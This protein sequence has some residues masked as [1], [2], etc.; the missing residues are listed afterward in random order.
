MIVVSDTSAIANLALVSHLWLLNQLYGQVVIPEVVANELAAAE[1]Q[2]IQETLE[3]DWII[4]QS[5]TDLPLATQLQQERGLDAGEAHAIALAV[6][7]EA[8]DLL[9]D[10][11]LGRREAMKLGLSIIGILGVLLAAKGQNHIPAVKPIV[12]DL[13]STAGFRVGAAL[14]QQV[15]ALA[16]ESV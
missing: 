4:I 7:I 12:D 1:E 16:K 5:L 3:L 11:R 9:M 8:T 13:I 6:E 14:Y 15:L 10:E 2:S